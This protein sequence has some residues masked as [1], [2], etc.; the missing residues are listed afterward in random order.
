MNYIDA[1]KTVLDANGK[2]YRAAGR[3]F[4]AAIEA[5]KPIE[6]H[7]AMLFPPSTAIL[8]SGVSY[9]RRLAALRALREASL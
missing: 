8:L 2:A 4:V 5:G 9:A 7:I 1:Y 3:Y 6:K